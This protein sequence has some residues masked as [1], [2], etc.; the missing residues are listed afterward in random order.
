MQLSGNNSLVSIIVLTD[1][2]R[3]SD[4]SQLCAICGLL[5]R[6]LNHGFYYHTILLIL[7]ESKQP[8]KFI[9]FEELLAVKEALDGKFLF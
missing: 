2:E 4:G 9:A 5:I 8:I 6:P 3:S 7:H 1:T